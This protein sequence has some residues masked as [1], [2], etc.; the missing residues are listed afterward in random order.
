MIDAHNHTLFSEDCEATLES[1]IE[2]A[3]SKGIKHY[4]ITDHL[5]LDYQ[6]KRYKFDL[7]HR[8][9]KEAIHA[10]Q[11]KYKDKIEIY[12]GLECGVQPHI[13][14][15]VEKII[16]NEGFDFVI[17]SMHTTHKKDLYNQDFYQGLSPLEAY[18]AYIKEF[19]ICLDTMS[20]YSV[21]GHL[22]IVKRYHTDL[23][24]VSLED[25]EEEIKDL[26]RVVIKKGKGIEINTSG[27][28]DAFNHAFPHPQILSWYQELGG[29]L[30]TLGSDAHFPERIAQFYP[31]ALESLESLGF[32]KIAVFKSMI[33]FFIDIEDVKNALN[34]T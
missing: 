4:T 15:E 5:D 12:Y 17:A 24:Q 18:R 34:L 19:T 20:H 26:L 7:N 23:H 30:I 3:I 14:E 21:V 33:P 31:Q 29:H 10:A 9:R 27:Y 11:E 1:M 22:D 16:L 32:K 8:E 28:K 13:I 6:D 25:V 2:S